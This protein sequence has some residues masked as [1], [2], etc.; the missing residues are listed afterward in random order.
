M[1][2]VPDN[3]EKNKP[4]KALIEELAKHAKTSSWNGFSPDKPDATNNVNMPNSSDK[5]HMSI[6][7]INK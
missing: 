1:M 4:H 6:K 5:Q 2:E 7:E 3:T